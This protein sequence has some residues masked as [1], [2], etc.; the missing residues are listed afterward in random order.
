M[1]I[2]SI[3]IIPARAGSKRIKNKNIIN[4]YGKPIIAHSILT[5]KKSKLFSRIIVSTD[6]K[7]I[8]KIAERYGAVCPYI[9]KKKLSNDKVSTKDVLLDAIKIIKSEKIPYHFL[10]YP[11]APL[12]TSND[13]INAFNLI[14]NKRADALLTV[15][16]FNSHPLRALHFS[17]SYLKFKWPKYQKCNSQNLANYYFDAG[18]FYIYKT[19]AITNIKNFFLKKTIPFILPI[20]KSI[21]LNTHEDLRLLKL[22]YNAEK[23]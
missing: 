22:F 17:K 23:K 15:S 6:S 18:A 19:S 10:F 20:K 3:C 9:R 11:T 2:K 14:K 8:Q 12:I 1:K 16:K 7:K 5:A 4:F 13:L 21:D